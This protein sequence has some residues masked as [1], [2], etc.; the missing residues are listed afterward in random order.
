MVIKATN[1]NFTF[2]TAPI[3]RGLQNYGILFPFNNGVSHRSYPQLLV[4]IRKNVD[5]LLPMLATFL[6]ELSYLHLHI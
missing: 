6:N 2:S 4:T 1:H 3:L 5:N